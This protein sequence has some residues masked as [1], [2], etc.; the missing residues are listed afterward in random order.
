MIVVDGD[1]WHNIGAKL[2]GFWVYNTLYRFDLRYYLKGVAIYPYSKSGDCRPSHPQ[3]FHARQSTLRIVGLQCRRVWL[4]F[5]DGELTK[6]MA[7]NRMTDGQRRT[8][9]LLYYGSSV[10]LAVHRRACLV[11]KS[12]IVAYSQ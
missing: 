1:C 2:N 11:S 4:K 10:E 12:R 3:K 6:S 9:R 5:R 7:W 8:L